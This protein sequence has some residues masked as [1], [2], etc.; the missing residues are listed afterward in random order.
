MLGLNEITGECCLLIFKRC[1]GEC[2]WMVLWLQ[3]N[4][5]FGIREN[6]DGIG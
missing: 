6:Y 2:P 4:G 1:P 5:N 3:I